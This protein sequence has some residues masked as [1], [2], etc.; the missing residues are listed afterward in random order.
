M[1]GDFSRSNPITGIE[2]RLA[3]AS[4]IVWKFNGDAKMFQNFDRGFRDVIIKGIAKACA[5][6]EHPFAGR[7]EK[8]AGHGWI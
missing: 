1:A 6:E 4:L 7:A 5:H 3:A 2:S 8:L